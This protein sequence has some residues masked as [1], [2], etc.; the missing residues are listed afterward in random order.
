MFRKCDVNKSRNI[1]KGEYVRCSG[2]KDPQWT[3]LVRQFD[4]N[5]DLLISWQ[6]GFNAAKYFDKHIL[7]LK[8]DD[9]EKITK[10][11]IEEAADY[12]EKMARI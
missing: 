7:T 10:F 2:K 9:F 12:R 1:N 8:K 4:L 11:E 5:K 6:E 3:A